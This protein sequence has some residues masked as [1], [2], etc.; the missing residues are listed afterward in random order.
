MPFFQMFLREG[1][2]NRGCDLPRDVLIP[3]PALVC[4][5]VNNES[6]ASKMNVNMDKNSVLFLPL[7]VSRLTDD[8]D[9]SMRCT[10]MQY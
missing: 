1:L 4:Y 6:K 9:C 2:T 10:F 7:G 5:H 8:S 3:P